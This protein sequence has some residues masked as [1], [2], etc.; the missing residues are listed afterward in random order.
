MCYSKIPWKYR[1]LFIDRFYCT[2][3]LG[4][5]NTQAHWPSAIITEMHTPL[6]LYMTSRR[7]KVLHTLKMSWDG[8]RSE[9]AVIKVGSYWFAINLMFPVHVSKYHTRKKMSSFRIEQ[10]S[11]RTLYTVS[12]CLLL[13]H[14]VPSQNSSMKTS[15]WYW[16]DKRQLVTLIFL[17]LLKR[18]PRVENLIAV[19]WQ[20]VMIWV[21]YNFYE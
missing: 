14:Q 5:K 6:C 13:K 19:D 20:I 16:K 2:T 4:G 11:S 9:G 21:L 3:Q 12:K 1:S 8:F 15:G 17:N 18:R 10:P 7:W